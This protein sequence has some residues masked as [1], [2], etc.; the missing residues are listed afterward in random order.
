[1]R[2]AAIVLALTFANVPLHAQAPAQKRSRVRLGLR[3][4]ISWY[5][6]T[7]CPSEGPGFPVTMSTP[8]FMRSSVARAVL[9]GGNAPCA[10]I[11]GHSAAVL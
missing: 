3:L 2:A 8:A 10:I 7:Q 1:M 6:A 5:Q 4:L 9:P 11:S